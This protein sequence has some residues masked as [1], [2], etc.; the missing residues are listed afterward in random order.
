VAK[1]LPGAIEDT[2]KVILGAASYLDEKRQRRQARKMEF[3]TA[4]SNITPGLSE[5]E[6]LALLG[7]P[8]DVVPIAPLMWRYQREK[9][10]G[11]IMFEDGYVIGY[12]KPEKAKG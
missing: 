2:G 8:D 1:H 5:K 12:K 11:F 3:L 7:P 4:W 6:V 9:L 10:V